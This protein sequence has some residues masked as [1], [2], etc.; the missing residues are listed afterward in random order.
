MGLFDGVLGNAMNSAL[1]NLGNLAQNNNALPAVMKL[2]QDHG[3]LPKIIEMFNQN[4]LAQEAGSWIG[5]GSNLPITAD[6]I[7]QVFSPAVLQEFAAK[8]GVS[9]D[10]AN[11]IIAKVLPEIINHLTPN[12]SIP[13]NHSDLLSQ[14]LALL[15]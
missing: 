10:E 7:Q 12:G 3:G 6:H 2:I 9:G 14:G 13:E 15:K 11:A 4:G 1:G 8:L 5:G